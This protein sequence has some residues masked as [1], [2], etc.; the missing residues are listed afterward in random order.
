[1]SKITLCADVGGSHITCRLFDL[2]TLSFADVAPVIRTVNCHGPADQILN[3]WAAAIAETAGNKP[4]GLLHGL[5]FAMPGPFD[6]P[7]GIGLFSGVEKFD[8]LNGVNIKEALATRLKLPGDTR[9]R[10]LN[11][12]ACFAIGES[13]TGGAQ[14]HERLLAI[15]LGTG[16]GTTFIEHHRPVAGVS[17]IPDDGFLYHIRLGNSI[18]DDWFSARWLLARYNA[19]TANKVEGVKQLAQM[20][21]N[22]PVAAKIFKEFGKNLGQFLAPWLTRFKAGGLVIG[23]NISAAYHLFGDTLS[24][25]LQT[26]GCTAGV[27]VSSMHQN[28]AL[29]GAAFLCDDDF[30]HSYISNLHA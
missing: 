3:D 23:G 19:Q 4:L 24:Q 26:E 16:F 6:Y 5:G 25:T 2:D 21:L 15:T 22:N 10:F 30:Y 28:S 7:N 27:Y 18:A 17:G 12:A 13:L 1:M 11:D 29:C 8:A 20:A 14:H 9:I